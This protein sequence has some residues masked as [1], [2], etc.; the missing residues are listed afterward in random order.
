MKARVELARTY[1]VMR[2]YEQSEIEFANVLLQP[3]PEGV[4]KTINEYMK[5]IEDAKEKH[6]L[7]AMVTLSLQDDSNVN[8]GNS[9]LASIGSG[10]AI[11]DRSL[12]AYLA[13]V[14][15]YKLAERDTFWITKAN[16]YAQQFAVEN[17]YDV[18]YPFVETGWQVKKKDYS[19]AFLAGAESL[20][21][22]NEARFTGK[23]LAA[24]YDRQLSQNEILSAKF[25][26]TDREYVK[27]TDA[28]RDSLTTELDGR[29]QKAQPDGS[30]YTATAMISVEKEKEDLR[31]D[32]NNNTYK[33]GFNYYDKLAGKMSYSAYYNLKARQ[34]HD[35]TTVTAL[36]V[37]S[38]RS[39]LTHTVGGSLINE[40]DK[41]SYL[42]FYA[43]HTK[44]TSNQDLFDF[45]KTIFG[46]SYSVNLDNDWLR[47]HPD[48]EGK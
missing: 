43:N 11:S 6:M 10:D 24:V 46:V 44:N 22:G 9:Y 34:N 17:D 18:T 33:V 32:V 8:N 4:R 15:T 25:K 39:D 36:N 35:T 28:G 16:I 20:T 42:T 7:N 3:I 38:K 19:L 37:D 45:D 26:M 27:T 48:W 14:H 1:F 2:L 31:T 41:R 23:S 21:Y 5:K 47:N 12:A 40:L 30:I 13:M 29:W